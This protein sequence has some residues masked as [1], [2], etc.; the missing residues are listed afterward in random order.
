[1]AEQLSASEHIERTPDLKE[2][3]SEYHLDFA[4]AFQI[5]RPK[6]NA[7]MERVRAEEKAAMKIKLESAKQSLDDSKAGSASG[8]SRPA[9]PEGSPKINGMEID[10]EDAAEGSE[11]ASAPNTPSTASVP[12]PQGDGDK[13]S[14]LRM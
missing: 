14:L 6:L 12:L 7:E 11:F 5:L 3:V 4:Q 13:V 10:G 9:T 2:L 1:M 8:G